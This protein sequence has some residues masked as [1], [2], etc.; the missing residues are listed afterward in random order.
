MH[1]APNAGAQPRWPRSEWATWWGGQAGPTCSEGSWEAPGCV[2]SPA[3]PCGDPAGRL[4]SRQR[5]CLLGLLWSPGSPAP[6][7]GQKGGASQT[8]GG[9]LAPAT[10][11]RSH[12]GLRRLTGPTGSCETHGSVLTPDRAPQEGD[13][14]QQGTGVLLPS[15]VRLGSPSAAGQPGAAQGQG[16]RGGSAAL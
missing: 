16:C 10:M 5:A 8:Q 2:V 14:P 3:P 12:R 9:T 1:R 11:A 4:G 13:A 7:S 15:G 6:S